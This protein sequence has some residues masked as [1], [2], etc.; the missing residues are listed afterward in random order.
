MEKIKSRTKVDIEKTENKLKLEAFN[1][2]SKRRLSGEFKLEIAPRI[3]TPTSPVVK[4]TFESKYRSLETKIDEKRFRKEQEKINDMT[5]K[6]GT[7][8]K[9]F[10]K[11]EDDLEFDKIRKDNRKKIALLECEGSSG[12]SKVESVASRISRFSQPDPQ[13]EVK[14]KTRD[15]DWGRV[16]QQE[17]TAILSSN[18]SPR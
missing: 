6:K 1:D 17:T 11:F 9:E 16:R 12:E 5:P 2:A 8:R 3:I 4:P 18:K 10:A 15:E 13:K 7:W 14:V